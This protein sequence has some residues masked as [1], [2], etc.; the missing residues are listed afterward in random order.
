MSNYRQRLKVWAR[1][2]LWLLWT[3]ALLASALI[4][5]L[6]LFGVIHPSEQA[7]SL[8]S[9]AF[10]LLFWLPL[11]LCAARGRSLGSRNQMTLEA[12]FGYL[13]FG[14]I[15]VVFTLE[16]LGSTIVSALAL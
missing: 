8:L 6:K 12:R 15:M 1:D 3:C 2:P 11:I 9:D 16:M 14:T 10:Q 13:A 7:F 4:S 5:Q